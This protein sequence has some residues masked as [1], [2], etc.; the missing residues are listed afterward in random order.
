[1]AYGRIEFRAYIPAA[2]DGQIAAWPALWTDGQDWPADGEA[3]IAGRPGR[4]RRRFTSTRRP[5]VPGIDV[6]GNFTGWHTFGM[7][8]RSRH[9][10]VLL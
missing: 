2:R 10:E 6:P 7:W 1:M 5:A 4:R 8:W 9:G 3:D